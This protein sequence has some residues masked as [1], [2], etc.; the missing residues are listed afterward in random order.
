MNLNENRLINRV[1]IFEFKFPTQKE[2]GKY[3]SKIPIVPKIVSIYFFFNLSLK[4]GRRRRRKKVGI[5]INLS[6]RYSANFRNRGYV[7][8]PGI[9]GNDGSR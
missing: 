6:Q 9:K 5:R 4:G 8:F 3:I 7:R 2:I 1:I